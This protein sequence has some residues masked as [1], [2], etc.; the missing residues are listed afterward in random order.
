MAEKMI[1][2]KV[3]GRIE[4]FLDSEYYCV[5]CGSPTVLEEYGA[6]DYYVGETFVCLTCAAEWSFNGSSKIDSK[7]IDSLRV[8]AEK[9]ES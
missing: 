2:A 1:K 9:K 8:A 5:D 6:S 3:R 7:S 4:Q